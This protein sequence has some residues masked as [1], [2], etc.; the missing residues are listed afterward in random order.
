MKN[1]FKMLEFNWKKNIFTGLVTNKENEY[2]IIWGRSTEPKLKI[3]A[4]NTPLFGL[5]FEG[6][7]TSQLLFSPSFE[8]ISEQKLNNKK[9]Y[10]DFSSEI[11]YIMLGES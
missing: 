6:N 9:E 8:F 7:I 5:R 3:S 10:N 1:T 11:F 4:E 2:Y